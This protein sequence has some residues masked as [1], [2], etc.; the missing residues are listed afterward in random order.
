MLHKDN[1]IK[2]AA[3]EAREREER[4]AILLYSLQILNVP[5][6]SSTIMM[7]LQSEEILQ[8]ERCRNAFVTDTESGFIG[9]AMQKSWRGWFREENGSFCQVGDVEIRSSQCQ[10]EILQVL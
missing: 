5:A 10:I 7:A 9:W 8:N 2:Q 4:H 1:Y 3:V 6:M